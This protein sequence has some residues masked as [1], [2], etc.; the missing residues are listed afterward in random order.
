MNALVGKK[1]LCLHHLFYDQ[2]GSMISKIVVPL[3]GSKTA[4]KAAEYAVN[5]A[6]QLNA[7]VIILSV[8]E[9]SALSATV[10]ASKTTL[11]T[12][13]PL[14]DYLQEVAEKNIGEIL[15]LCE[16]NRVVS[17]MFIKKGHPVKEILKLAK[18]SKADLIVM[19]SHGLSALSATVLGS[20]SYGVIHHGKDVHVLIV[21]G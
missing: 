9:K 15:K 13:E 16:K 12:I 6:K 1:G 2:E 14:E 11:H 17:E 5:L 20:V 7:S 21:R 19:G 8:I 18:K 4:R 10:P 3:D